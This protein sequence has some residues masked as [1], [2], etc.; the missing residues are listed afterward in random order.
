NYAE[1][2]M[3]YRDKLMIF[4]HEDDLLERLWNNL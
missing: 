1:W 4:D 2:A 3:D